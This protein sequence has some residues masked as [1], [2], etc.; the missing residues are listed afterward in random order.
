MKASPGTM[1]ALGNAWQAL[2]AAA[3]LLNSK[4]TGP[5]STTLKQQL[6]AIHA[7]ANILAES[8][9]YSTSEVDLQIWHNLQQTM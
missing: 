5:M 6:V 4:L 9:G 3:K 1:A 2:V 7:K 8:F